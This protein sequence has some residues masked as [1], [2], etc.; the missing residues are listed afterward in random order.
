MGS[1][2]YH[3]AHHLFPDV[4]HLFYPEITRMLENFA[5]ENNLPYSKQSL[6]GSLYAHYTLLKQNA[7]THNIFEETM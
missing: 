3:I 5:R 4:H 6:S 1:F 2:N 7:V